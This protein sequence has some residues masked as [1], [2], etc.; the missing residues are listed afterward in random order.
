MN[1]NCIYIHRNKIN[2]KIYVGKT[3]NIK[4]RWSRN[5]ER[6]SGCSYFYSAIQ[7]Y[8]WNNFEHIVIEE[9]IDNQHI[10]EREQYWIQYY[11]SNNKEY[12][13]NLTTGGDGGELN[14]ETRK[15]MSQSRKNYLDKSNIK[16]PVI[17]LETGE[18][19]S[20]AHEIEKEKGI[21]HTQ[22]NACCLHYKSSY[23]AQGFHWVYL[24]EMPDWSK[25]IAIQK[26]QEIESL[27]GGTPL[28]KEKAYIAR[29]SARGKQV[30]CITNNTTYLSVR[31]AG[32]ALNIDSSSISRVCLGKQK[33]TKG[34][35]FRF[36]D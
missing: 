19:F 9:N 33:S 18:I 1:K 29:V 26:I 11:N 25:E 30:Y 22:I 21:L 20:S 12:G 34:Y 2:N 17:C 31:E 32:R 5:G 16:K 35:K 27:R 6:Y 28:E 36:L 4:E 14:L 7:K 8:G 13:Y 10:D 23:T 15:K 3:K 24:E